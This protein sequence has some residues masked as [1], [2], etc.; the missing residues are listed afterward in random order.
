MKSWG[1]GSGDLACPAG[2]GPNA[3]GGRSGGSR[4]GRIGGV[5]GRA[6]VVRRTRGACCCSGANN[7]ALSRR[8]IVVIFASWE[9]SASGHIMH[10]AHACL[11][12]VNYDTTNVFKQLAE[13]KRLLDT[14][15]SVTTAV[16]CCFYSFCQ[17]CSVT[18]WQ[19]TP[20]ITNMLP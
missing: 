7:A 9:T 20:V 10:G 1:S 3:P 4:R 2:P 16:S 14:L 19:N 18:R 15:V 8:I 12:P 6:G 13:K 17:T 5:G 11:V